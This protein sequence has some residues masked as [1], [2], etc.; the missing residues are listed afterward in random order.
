MQG[1]QL[2]YQTHKKMQ[3]ACELKSTVAILSGIMIPHFGILIGQSNKAISNLGM[4][5]TGE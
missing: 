1:L 4:S 3:M 5:T 2:V